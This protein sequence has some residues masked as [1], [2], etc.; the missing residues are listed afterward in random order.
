MGDQRYCSTG[1]RLNLLILLYIKN[2]VSALW[3]ME[4][5]VSIVGPVDLSHEAQILVSIISHFLM[6]TLLSELTFTRFDTHKM[7]NFCWKVFDSVVI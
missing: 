1:L 4:L 7:W 3:D 5:I 6:H 2:V